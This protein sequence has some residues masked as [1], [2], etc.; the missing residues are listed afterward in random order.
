MKDSDIATLEAQRISLEHKLTRVDEDLFSSSPVNG[1]WS[2]IQILEHIVISE[3]MAILYVNK[4]IKSPELLNSVTMKTKI[5]A[6]LMNNLL[7]YNFRFKAPQKVNP[8]HYPTSKVENILHRWQQ[9]RIS[10]EQLSR[11]SPVV[12]EKGI[13]K[14]P[15]V[16]YLNFSQM[17][18]FLKSH[19]EH[20]LT[21]ISV[22][23]D[24]RK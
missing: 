7:K 12:L 16:G 17:V 18:D 8:S 21:Q 14:H 19:F 13:F 22:I 24:Q 2:I 4:K 9:A 20:H 23:V 5:Y 10:L 11:M 6:I 1:K 3:E 15:G